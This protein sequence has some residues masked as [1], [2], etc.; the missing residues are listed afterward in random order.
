MFAKEQIDEL[1]RSMTEGLKPV[2]TAAVG[3]ILA[4]LVP[5]IH[6]AIESGIDRFH[7]AQIELSP[8]TVTIKLPPAKAESV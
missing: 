1:S 3:Q 4:Q 6:N 8:I 7:G 2:V 5:E